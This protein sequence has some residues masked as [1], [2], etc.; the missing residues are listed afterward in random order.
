MST[1][2]SETN[3]REARHQ[4]IRDITSRFSGV[5]DEKD[6]LLIEEMIATCL[7]LGHDDSN[8]GEMKLLN[9]ALKE[10]RYAYTVFRPWNHRPKISIFG[11]ARTA[12]DHPDYA[13][14]RE[15]S[16]LMGEAE[17]MTITGAGDG[18]MKAGHEGP[19]QDASFGLRIRLPF[20]TT[21]NDVIAEDPKLVNFRYFF[22]RKLM[23]LT[24]SEA[25][26]ALPGGFGTM[27]ELFETLTL[28]QTGKSQPIPVILLE[29]ESGTYWPRWEKFLQKELLD[30]GWISPADLSLFKIAKS[31]E[32]ARDLVLNAYRVYHSSRYVKNR[33]VIRLKQTPTEE[34][35]K[36]LESQFGD[37]AKDG[38]FEV[39][40][41]LEG[42]T[43]AL[44]LSRLHFIH[45]RRDFGKLSQLLD[46]IN[47]L[48]EPS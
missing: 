7:R 8:T 3:S 5:E 41:P 20:E 30:N 19:G 48:A 14:A 38:V 1:N 12:E 15:L 40:G 21:A 24:H 36:D 42:E 2:Q 39:S 37:L 45:T 31:P 28:I 17:W 46:A 6:Q 25:V 27:D 47:M 32:H 4:A 44:E 34:Q 11:S 23:F 22:T 26:A 35:R 43:S 18:I 9:A 29:G 13:A 10:M 16:R 33:F